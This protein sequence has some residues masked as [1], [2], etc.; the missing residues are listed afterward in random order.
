MNFDH[1]ISTLRARRPARVAF[2][3][4]AAIAAPCVLAC[5]SQVAE[6]GSATQAQAATVSATPSGWTTPADGSPVHIPTSGLAS[7]PPSR[8]T[9]TAPAP[10]DGECKPATD[11][12]G[13]CSIAAG[14]SSFFACAN[15]DLPPAGSDCMGMGGHKPWCCK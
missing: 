4:L 2:A 15:P 12:T 9:A 5:S 11:V 3:A 10:T 7:P 6:E 13:I 14:R 8:P 1:L